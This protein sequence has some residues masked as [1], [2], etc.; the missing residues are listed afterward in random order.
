MYNS[1]GHV[2]YLYTTLADYN[3]SRRPIQE[4]VLLR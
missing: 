1:T 2:C 4:A 3:H